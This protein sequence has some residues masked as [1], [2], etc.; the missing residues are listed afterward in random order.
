MS[1]FNN[2]FKSKEREEQERRDT[3]LN[4]LLEQRL[5]TSKGDCD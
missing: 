4:R 1:I 2:L 3:E 5:I